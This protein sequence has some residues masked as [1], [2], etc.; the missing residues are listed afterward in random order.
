MTKWEKDYETA[1]WWIFYRKRN[2]DLIRIQGPFLGTDTQHTE[3]EGD[4]KDTMLMPSGTQ[5]GME[6]D[7]SI[8]GAFGEISTLAQALK[9]IIQTRYSEEIIQRTEFVINVEDNAQEVNLNS[10]TSGWH[11]FQWRVDAEVASGNM[12]LVRNK[13]VKIHGGSWTYKAYRITVDGRQPYKLKQM[14]PTY[15]EKNMK[16]SRVHISVS[17]RMI[18]AIPVAKLHGRENHNHFNGWIEFV[19][20]VP[21]EPSKFEL[22]PSPCTTKVSFYENDE[23]FKIFKGSY[24]EIQKEPLIPTLPTSRSSTPSPEP[25]EPAPEPPAPAPLPVVVLDDKPVP[26]AEV[27]I[28]DLDSESEEEEEEEV[29]TPEQKIDSWGISIELK[30]GIL[31]IRYGGRL[32]HHLNGGGR[33][34]DKDSLKQRIIRCNNIEEAKKIIKAW[35]KLMA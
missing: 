1:N 9:E 18:E 23:I 30:E 21:D 8:L 2:R 15:G 31:Y 14:F 22:M 34:A 7:I 28:V 26:I 12:R 29:I 16:C 20:F 10:K 25:P 27:D 35:V 4:G 3:V 17:G 33:E 19:N 32:Q 6:F 11:S 13:V 24:L 5:W